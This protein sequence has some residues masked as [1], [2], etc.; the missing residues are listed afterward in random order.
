MVKRKESDEIDRL[1]ESLDRLLADEERAA[2][3]Q[4]TRRVIVLTEDMAVESPQQ[5]LP[6]E[7]AKRERPK[8]KEEETKPSDGDQGQAQPPEE[9][10]PK[11]IP[12]PWLAFA[13]FAAEAF[14]SELSRALPMIVERALQRAWERMQESEKGEANNGDGDRKTL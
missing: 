4:R 2:D 13:R 6:L 9:A 5:A 14:A 8:P 1:L 7:G 11:A 10:A 3:E 12:E